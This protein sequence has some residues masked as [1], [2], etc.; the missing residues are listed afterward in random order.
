MD[1]APWTFAWHPTMPE[2]RP[3]RVAMRK[4]VS[5]AAVLIC[6]SGFTAGP[7]S[8]QPAQVETAAM[9]L[10]KARKAHDEN[11]PALAASHFREFLAKFPQHEELAAVRYGLALALLETPGADLAEPR[12]LLQALAAKREGAPDQALV[13]Y[14]L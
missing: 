5:L 3:Q 4:T 10:A 11:Q 7:A 8:G 1:F 14:Q 9:V 6:A 13:I 2:P 12:D